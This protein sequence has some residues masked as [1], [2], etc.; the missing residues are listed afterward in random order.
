[1]IASP[2][3][4][5]IILSTWYEAQVFQLNSEGESQILIIFDNILYIKVVQ[6]LSD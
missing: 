6:K 4:T 1:M 2:Y 5:I 3:N